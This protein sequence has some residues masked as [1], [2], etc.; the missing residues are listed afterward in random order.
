MNTAPSEG[1]KSAVREKFK[2][3]VDKKG[4]GRDRDVKDHQRCPIV[5]GLEAK[6][7]CVQLDGHNRPG[8]FKLKPVI[9]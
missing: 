3:T 1:T 5:V 8:T 2:R 9:R 6:Q 7:Y 4:R